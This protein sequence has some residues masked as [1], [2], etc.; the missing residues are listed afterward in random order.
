MNV[1]PNRH[2]DDAHDDESPDATDSDILVLA[3]GDRGTVF[4]G[5]VL[6]GGSS[7]G[8]FHTLAVRAAG[9]FP[10]GEALSAIFTLAVFASGVVFLV[11]GAASIVAKKNADS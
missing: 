10:T 5:A 6:V 8:A 9:S 11:E 4:I 2:R 7:Y 1:D 3:T